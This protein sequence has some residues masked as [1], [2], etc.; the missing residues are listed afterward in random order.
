MMMIL[1]C[2]VHVYFQ[3]FQHAC[4]FTPTVSLFQFPC[5]LQLPCRLTHSSVDIV[6]L[7]ALC[8]MYLPFCLFMYSIFSC[9]ALYASPTATVSA[10]NIKWWKKHSNPLLESSNTTIKKIA[11]TPSLFKAA[12]SEV[13]LFSA[14]KF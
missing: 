1:S 2:R 4:I 6:G 13:E 7:A 3:Y 10:Y 8:Y 5:V 11:L 14:T 9:R 12:N